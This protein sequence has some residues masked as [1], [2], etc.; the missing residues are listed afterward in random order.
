MNETRVN[1]IFKNGMIYTLDNK[2][3]W[4]QAMI[5]AADRL[6]YVGSNEG[7]ES[8][9]DAGGE[10]IDLEGRLVLPS[11]V[12]AHAHPSHAVDFF[13]NISLYQLT[14]VDQYREKILE[15][16]ADHPDQL[17]YRGN[18]WDNTLFPLHGPGKGIL[19][20]IVPDKPLVLISYDYHSMWV[21]TAMLAF[22]GI[23]RDTPNPDGGIIERDSQTREPS[24]TLRETAMKLV[25]AVLPDFSLED[26]VNTLISYQKM[27]FASGVTMC[28]DAMLDEDTLAGYK[29]LA[30]AGALEMIFRGSIAIEPDKPIGEQIEMLLDERANNKDPKFK[31]N[32]AKLFVDGVVEGGTAY[33]LEPYSNQSAYYGELIWEPGVLKEVCTALDKEQIQVHMHV[34]GDGA[35][36]IALDALEHAQQQNGK[37]DAR[38]LLTHLQLVTPQD[39]KRF[40]QLGIVGVPNPFW[41]KVD[42]YYSALALPYLGAERA[43]QQYPMRSFLD[44]G[45]CMASASDFPVTIPF[46]PLIGIELG[47]TRSPV[48]TVTDEI[49]WPEEKASLEQMITSFTIN[50]AY[51]NFLENETG[52]L[53]VGKQADFIVLDQNLFEIE[54]SEISTTKILN[55][56]L[57]GEEV[58]QAE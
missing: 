42:E 7:A 16:T 5:V 38:H 54:A 50:G 22:S 3:S 33:L 46:D 58:F 11:F 36:R 47:V 1:K 41:F 14:S 48:G 29:A 39:I 30:A 19:D 51:A 55:T 2:N 57:Q 37:R 52:T 25:E 6:I 44:A 53:E 20:A 26:K 43:N 4:A 8:W 31:S 21:N 28:H 18:G 9:I 15:Y 56:Y 13:E 34:I 27:A 24:G 10:V 17:V 12:E 32:T 23:T 40:K 45:V 49:L 35:A